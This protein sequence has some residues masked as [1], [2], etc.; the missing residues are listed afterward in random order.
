MTAKEK[1][2]L[3]DEFINE[4]GLWHDFLAFADSKGYTEGE[5]DTE[6]KE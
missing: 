5:I 6:E 2:V 3:M 4:N 1:V